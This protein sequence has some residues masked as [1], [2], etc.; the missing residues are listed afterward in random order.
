MLKKANT[1]GTV[2]EFIAAR[3]PIEHNPEHG[4]KMSRNQL[5]LLAGQLEKKFRRPGR[6]KEKVCSLVL[7]W[8]LYLDTLKIPVAQ[9]AA[10]KWFCADTVILPEDEDKVL[11]AVKT[12]KIHHVDP[13]VYDS[14]MSIMD[15]FGMPRRKGGPIDP[16]SVAT[17]HLNKRCGNGV[18]IFDVDESP[19]SR[20]NMREIINTH[21]GKGYSPW[22]LLQGD[23]NGNLTERSALYWNYYNA[24]PKRVAFK[25]GHLFAFSAGKEKV[26]VWWNRL[27]NIISREKEVDLE[28]PDDP[29]FR[30]ARF[31]VD[32]FTGDQRLLGKIYKGNPV[33]GWCEHYHTLDDTEPYKK[34]YYFGGRRLKGAWPGMD[35]RTEKQLAEGSDLARGMIRVPST[36]GEIKA[37]PILRDAALKELILPDSITSVDPDTFRRNGTIRRIKLPSRMT[38]LPPE[39]FS[40]C[41]SLESVELPAGLKKISAHTFRDCRSLKSITIP[42]SVSEIGEG[43][44]EDCLSLTSIDLPEGL[45]TIHQDT[46]KGCSGLREIALPKGLE[47]I[48]KSAFCRCSSLRE[49]TLPQS[50]RLIGNGAFSGCSSLAEVTI[51]AAVTQM[52]E[53]AFSLCFGVVRYNVPQRW[54]ALFHDRYGRRVHIAA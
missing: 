51:P 25:D 24:Y 47:E 32:P 7:E 38:E 42:G 6:K 39:F 3:Y 19:E 50:V 36:I 44:F 23:K 53:A 4:K 18:D 15:K 9:R 20:K 30:R 17:L 11:Q 33:C 14:P 43:A 10:C 13:L 2:A 8:I 41:Y 28:V 54:Y 29:L 27:D 37:N 22:C 40:G 46:F 21:F 49:L 45:V 26:R 5:N 48:G 52:G 34:G 1:P 35:L 16:M 12:A 31:I